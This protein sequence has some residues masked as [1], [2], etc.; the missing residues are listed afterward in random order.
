MSKSLKI[1]SL[2][3]FFV[4]LFPFSYNLKERYWLNKPLKLKPHK[5]LEI[6]RK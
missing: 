3:N 4:L 6:M 1:S 5:R 2:L